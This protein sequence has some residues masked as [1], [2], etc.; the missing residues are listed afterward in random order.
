MATLSILQ[1]CWG[2]I[3]PEDLEVLLTVSE[4]RAKRPLVEL[5]SQEFC[6]VQLTSLSES[7]ENLKI[8]KD[9]N[10]GHL[11]QTTLSS[12]KAKLAMKSFSQ[13]T[14]LPSKK[15]KNSSKNN[16]E[17]E[18]SEISGLGLPLGMLIDKKP[19]K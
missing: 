16:E 3:T 10:E 7:E 12:Y 2:I 8:K 5:L 11:G 13:Q 14:S 6:L 9:E 17:G 18:G 4:A 19:E 1:T 15:S